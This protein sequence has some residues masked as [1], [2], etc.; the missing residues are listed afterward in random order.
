MFRQYK[1][2]F[3]IKYFGEQQAVLEAFYRLNVQSIITRKKS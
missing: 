2:F 1:V 3:N